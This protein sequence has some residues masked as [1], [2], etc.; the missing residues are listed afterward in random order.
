M[1]APASTAYCS[2]ITRTSAKVIAITAA[3]SLSALQISR[4]ARG[5]IA[6]AAA[7][8]RMPAVTASG[9]CWTSGAAARTTTI[10]TTPAI[11]A[12]PARPRAG[13]HVEGGRLHRAAHRAAAEDAAGDVGGALTHEVAARVAQAVVG[14]GHRAADA[15]ALDQPDDGQRQ[16]REE[17]SG[18]PGRGPAGAA[19][20]SRRGWARCRRRPARTSARGAATAAETTTSAP[21]WRRA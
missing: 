6:L 12:R 16:G 13:A 9:T 17:E 21:P 7:T 19:G 4:A 11:T 20:G 1:A 18:Q 3:D 5:L 2:G 10:T 8:I 15:G 14:V